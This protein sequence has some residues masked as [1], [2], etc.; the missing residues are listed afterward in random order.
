MRAREPLPQREKSVPAQQ[1]SRDRADAAIKTAADAAA[2]SRTIDDPEFRFATS[3]AGGGGG[4]AASDV[5]E[6]N[7]AERMLQR[8]RSS[9]RVGVH[10]GA[11]SRCARV[12]DDE[13]ATVEDSGAGRNSREW[14]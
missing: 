9:S 2:K 6:L 3:N 8:L 12:S 1:V 11:E 7:M 4:G 10:G 5:K 14:P 13:R